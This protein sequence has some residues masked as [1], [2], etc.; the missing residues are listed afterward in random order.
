MSDND[1]STASVIRNPWPSWAP[2]GTNAFARHW[3]FE[4]EDPISLPVSPD[5]LSDSD[6]QVTAER[7]ESPHLLLATTVTTANAWSDAIFFDAFY[8]LFERLEAH[9]GR[10]RSIQGQA[11]EQWRPFRS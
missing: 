2:A 8:R 1:Y 10:L 4:F 5:G 3:I 11:R 7:G 6:L 9:F